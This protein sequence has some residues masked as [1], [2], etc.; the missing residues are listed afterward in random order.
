MKS[1]F[2]GVA[3]SKVFCR[4]LSFATEGLLLMSD[5]RKPLGDLG[6]LR[7]LS[8]SSFVGTRRKEPKLPPRTRFRSVPPR[9]RGALL[10]IEGVLTVSEES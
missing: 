9:H 3:T 5:F 2:F 10:D 4:I 6:S 7:G 1:L 8:T